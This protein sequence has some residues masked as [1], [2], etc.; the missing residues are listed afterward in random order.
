MK[1]FLNSY[2][3]ITAT[4][5]GRAAAKQFDIHPLEDGSIRREPDLTHVKPCISGLCRPRSMKDIK[6]EVGDI[7]IYKTNGSHQLA[8]ILEVEHFFETHKD[9]ADYFANHNLPV[10]SNNITRDPL[11]LEMSHIKDFQHAANGSDRLKERVLQTWDADYQDRGSKPGNTY[12]IMTRSIY[13]A[14]YDR[15]P[16]SD[17]IKIGDLLRRHFTSVPNTSWRPQ[18]L[19]D[20]FYRDLLSITKG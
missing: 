11:P 17:I 16:L 4:P 9:A 7:M 8:A 1:I 5:F 2:Y 19:N 13:N 15:I 18:L 10:P 6:L 3:P 12:F 20:D 14:V